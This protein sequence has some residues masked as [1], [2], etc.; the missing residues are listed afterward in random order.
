MLAVW[1]WTIIFSLANF[2]IFFIYTLFE[3][4]R[5]NNIVFLL[6]TLISYVGL[7]IV[8]VIIK[9]YLAEKYLYTANTDSENTLSVFYKYC[10]YIP[11]IDGALAIVRWLI[12]PNILFFAFNF[13][14]LTVS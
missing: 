14:I 5:S 6:I 4:V 10:H 12:N 9:L 7:G 3:K 13:F 8:H 11:V 2:Y 1:T